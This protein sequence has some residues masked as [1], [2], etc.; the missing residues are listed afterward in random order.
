MNQEPFVA[1]PISASG[2]MKPAQNQPIKAQQNQPIRN[3]PN[4][5]IRNQPN[6][7]VRNQP[8]RPQQMRRAPQPKIYNLTT[9][10]MPYTIMTV[11][12]RYHTGIGQFEKL[13]FFIF[14]FFVT[15]IWGMNIYGAA[16]G[17]AGGMSSAEDQK[18][19][20]SVKFLFVIE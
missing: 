17:D 14:R 4:Q 10:D 8:I 9:F 12:F 3:Q 16:T 7:P 13:F 19:W 5:P 6:Q 20:V 11:G 2:P 1:L 18:L 15:L